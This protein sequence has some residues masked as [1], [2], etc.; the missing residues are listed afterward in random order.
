MLVCEEAGGR[1]SDLD[2]NTLTFPDE[3]SVGRSLVATNSIVHNK[4]IEYLR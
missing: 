1:I 2:G 3:V 4:V